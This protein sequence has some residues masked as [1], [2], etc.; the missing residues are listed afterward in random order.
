L[1]V[2]AGA[3]LGSSDFGMS[4]NSCIFVGDIPAASWRSSENFTLTAFLQGI[5]HRRHRW[6]HH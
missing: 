6:C 5:F 2:I 1:N 3:S 4:V